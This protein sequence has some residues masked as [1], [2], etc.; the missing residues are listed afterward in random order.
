[1]LRSRA[2]TLDHRAADGSENRPTSSHDRSRRKSGSVYPFPAGEGTAV[3]ADLLFRTV[4]RVDPK[5]RAGR[6]LPPA[7]LKSH[8]V[9]RLRR[10]P[11]EDWRRVSEIELKFL[12]VNLS[13]SQAR[14]YSLCREDGVAFIN[15]DYEK[16]NCFGRARG[17]EREPERG[18]R[19][20]VCFDMRFER[21]ALCAHEHGF[22]VMA[23]SLGISRW[24]NVARIND[25]GMRAVA[26]MTACPLGFQ[27]AQGWRVIVPRSIWSPHLVSAKSRGGEASGPGGSRNMAAGQAELHAELAHAKKWL[28][29]EL[30]TFISVPITIGYWNGCKSRLLHQ[31][32]LWL[33]GAGILFPGHLKDVS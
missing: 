22:P 25:C 7:R 17:M 4:H 6:F 11:E 5:G 27:L 2:R 18:V 10:S 31:R 20:T 33:F 16:D 21:T 26:L 19:C 15:A 14:E 9:Q 28:F 23:S 8:N 24:K 32:T 12:L 1:M 3:D 13:S 29:C 30:P